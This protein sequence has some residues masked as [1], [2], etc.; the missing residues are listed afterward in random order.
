MQYM[1]ELLRSKKQ[2][3]DLSAFE[4][5]LVGWI[6]GNATG[7]SSRQTLAAANFILQSKYAR[8]ELNGKFSFLVWYFTFPIQKVI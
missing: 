8:T 1:D 2:A 5:R 6:I 4:T 7:S 3:A